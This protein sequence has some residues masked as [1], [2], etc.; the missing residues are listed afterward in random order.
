VLILKEGLDIHQSKVP[1]AL[2]PFHA[3]MES[4]YKEM[5]IVLEREYGIKV[6]RTA[7]VV[8][9]MLK[10]LLIKTATDFDKILHRGSWNG[11]RSSHSDFSG[12]PIQ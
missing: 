1:E 6:S 7:R 12:R 5:K 9:K 4:R 10:Y 11:P 2:Q 3:H 8:R